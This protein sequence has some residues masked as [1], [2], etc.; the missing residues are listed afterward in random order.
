[1]TTENEKNPWLDQWISTKK[2][3]P[4]YLYFMNDL[5]IF[6]NILRLQMISHDGIETFWDINLLKL[7]QRHNELIELSDPEDAKESK[8]ALL[9]VLQRAIKMTEKAECG[10]LELLIREQREKNSFIVHSQFK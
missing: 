7:I 5:A 2:R 9:K 4:E 10:K 8:Q 6:G 3:N 1:M